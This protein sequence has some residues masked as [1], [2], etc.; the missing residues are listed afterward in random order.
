M[1]VLGTVHIGYFI[2]WGLD[3]IKCKVL[4]LLIDL[5]IDRTKGAVEILS[6]NLRIIE[7]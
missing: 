6:L 4:I 3:M 1:N 7:K 2:G 5:Q